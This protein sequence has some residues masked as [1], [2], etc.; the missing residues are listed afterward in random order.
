[1]KI[2]RTNLNIFV[3]T[4]VVGLYAAT[5]VTVLFELVESCIT[6]LF[7]NKTSSEVWQ[8]VFKEPKFYLYIISILVVL[9]LISRILLVAA[10]FVLTIAK[11]NYFLNA[12]NILQE[13]KDFKIFLSNKKNAFTA[14]F[15]NPTIYVSSEL[16]KSFSKQSFKKVILH[17]KFHVE[18][19]DP[20]KQ[21]IFSKLILLLPPFFFK[22]EIINEFLKDNENTA[23][24]NLDI[25]FQIDGINKSLA[26]SN[27][28]G[29]FE[30]DI[31]K[32]NSLY[33]DMFSVVMLGFVFLFTFSIGL[34]ITS[35]P[36]SACS[37]HDTCSIINQSSSVQSLPSQC[38]ETLY[39]PSKN[40]SS[41]F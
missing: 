6:E 7:F 15:L 11:T 35:N 9:Y 33:K 40:Y 21:L 25:L 22:K 1:M 10:S 31:L 38:I 12:L 29:E 30:A 16:V 2:N 8:A 3:T 36:L 28:G 41:P 20:L 5:I 32:V 37:N 17:E 27:Y 19:K 13:K 24:I 39:S 26:L 23:E 34:F 18:N 4:F 14:G